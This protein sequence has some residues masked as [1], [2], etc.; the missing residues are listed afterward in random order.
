MRVK[1]FFGFVNEG[2]DIP[3]IGFVRKTASALLDKVKS[4]RS[5][6]SEEYVEFRGMRFTQPFEFELILRIKRGTDVVNDQHFKDL[7]WEKINTQEKGYAID[8]S[9]KV[10]LE[11]ENL[12]IITIHI[13]MD[14]SKEPHSYKELYYRL[15]D[16]LVHETTHLKQVGINKEPS[17]SEPTHQ[18][19]R[20]IAKS[21]ADYFLMSDETESMVEGMYAR[22]KEKG[23][24]IDTIFVDYLTPLL[25]SGFI[26][27]SE[28]DRVM[29]SWMKKVVELHPDVEISQND[30]RRSRKA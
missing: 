17:A 5:N 19:H 7:P 14:P 18:K 23:S 20:E 1:S 13:M 27:Q 15:I 16:I 11:E 8:A 25:K 29:T 12:P 4:D 2:S 22:A 30:E 10:D 28:F 21:G 26:T 9:T 24:A 6:K 3:E